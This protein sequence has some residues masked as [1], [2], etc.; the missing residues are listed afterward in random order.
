MSCVADVSYNFQP[1]CFQ[2]L[3]FMTNN[4][5]NSDCVIRLNNVTLVT[6]KNSQTFS[7]SLNVRL[8]GFEMM[9]IKHSDNIIVTVLSSCFDTL[10][11]CVCVLD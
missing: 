3:L 5:R 10:Y 9:N 8:R 1:N 7:T 11:V 4:S 6:L 2:D